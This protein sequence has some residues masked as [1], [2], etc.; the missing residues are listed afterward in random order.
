MADAK[1]HARLGPSSSDIWLTCLGAPAE[2][3]KY[4]PKVVGFAAKEGTLA[5]ALCEAALKLNAVPWTEGMKFKVDGEEIEVTQEMLN[6]VSLFAVTTSRISDF[7][8]W[9]MVE[10]EVSLGWLWA[11][12]NG[13]AAAPP[14]EVF[15]TADFAA[16]DAITLYIVDF[17]YG[18]GKAVHPE[19]NTQELCYAVGVLG[20]LMRE[21]PELAASIESVCMLIVQPR[22]GGAP[23][24]SWTL[25]VGELLYWAYAV[26]KPAIE[27]IVAGRGLQLVAGNH[28]YFCAASIECPAYRRLKLQRS[29]DSFPDYDPELDEEGVV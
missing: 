28:C 27:R 4:P 22:A 16:C 24:R 23:V 10:E 5:H 29:I 26:L 21:R 2:W 9:R 3:A 13:A 7:S 8:H 20:R 15:G 25:S 17:K 11:P 12:T 6:A 1:R 18:R 19:G 14:E